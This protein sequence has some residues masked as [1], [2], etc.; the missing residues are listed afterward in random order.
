[1][2][3]GGRSSLQ[4]SPGHGE[5][6]RLMEPFSR[7]PFWLYPLDGPGAQEG[8]GLLSWVCGLLEVGTHIGHTQPSLADPVYTVPGL[9]T[10]PLSLPDSPSCLSRMP[11]PP[12]RPP[13]APVVAVSHCRVNVGSFVQ[14]GLE[15]TILCPS[16]TQHRA[17]LK[18]NI[19]QIFF[20][21]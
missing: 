18:V 10:L 17:W 13:R 2:E 9:T 5:H 15:L 14:Q 20:E 3:R 7:R 8:S 21:C 4:P 12:G 16:G 6:N 19:S 11:P 1:M